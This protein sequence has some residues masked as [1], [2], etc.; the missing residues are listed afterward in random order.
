MEMEMDRQLFVL[1]PEIWSSIDKS[2]VMATASSMR[3]AGV[4][5]LPYEEFDISA[6]GET[7][8][9]MT[10]IYQVIDDYGDTWNS[11][12]EDKTPVELHFRYKVV[13]EKHYTYSMKVNV[14][15][16]Y[17][18]LPQGSDELL[19]AFKSLGPDSAHYMNDIAADALLT[20]LNVM[21]A[22]RNVDKD[23]SHNPKRYKDPMSKSGIKQIKNND[24]EYITIIKIGKIVDTM[25]SDGHRG[26]V[27]PHLRRGH[28][29][30]QRI[31][32]GRK[33]VK[34]IFI[35]PVFVNADEGWI[36][37]QRKEYRVKM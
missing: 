12:K 19:S 2:E 23:V 33:D 32:E 6:Y 17:I 30:N 13:D 7:R 24:Y 4:Y 8:H 34:Q 15:N 25:R 1:G 28:V 20:T 11:I 36:E 37:N 16:S 14:G 29:R 27:R 26:P 5:D 3:D 35:Q 18:F 31:G 10:W 22:T 9:I 21:L